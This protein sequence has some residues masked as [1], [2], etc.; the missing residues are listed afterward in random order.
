MYT[1]ERRRHVLGARVRLGLLTTLAVALCTGCD[2]LMVVEGRVY[3]T[4][5][6][7]GGKTGL[8]LVDSLD[9]TLP[10]RLVPVAGAEVSIE[11]WR[12]DQ[13][14]KTDTRQLWT[15]RTRTDPTGYFKTGGTV[16]PGWYDATITVTC[17]GFHEV[18]AVF[19]HDRFEHRAVVVLARQA[20]P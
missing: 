11:P 12:P 10:S 7:E 14:P 3:E 17:P 20:S 2:G 4:V 15:R 19:R 5:Q 18:Q 16:K 1:Q 9:R 13:R 8:V 6:P